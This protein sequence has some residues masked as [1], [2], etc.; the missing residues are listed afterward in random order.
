MMETQDTIP[1]S[2]DFEYNKLY[3]STEEE[4]GYKMSDGQIKAMITIY[5]I[6]CAL[7]IML[8]CFLIYVLVR[9]RK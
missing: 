1:K 3:E 6:D 2:Q 8:S 5:G 4:V 9:Y 7:L